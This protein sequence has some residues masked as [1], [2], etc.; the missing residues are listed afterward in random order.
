MTMHIIFA[1][2]IFSSENSEK[3]K[4]FIITKTTD[5]A[6]NW[7]E[8]ELMY[9]IL[10]FVKVYCR[11]RPLDNPDDNCCVKPLS[12]T[13]VQ[14]IPPEVRGQYGLHVSYSSTAPTQQ[15]DLCRSA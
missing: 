11:V 12:T 5:N 10:W 6:V 1:Y 15:K 4:N 9:D 2:W 8:S 7:K 14:L 13:L 3:S